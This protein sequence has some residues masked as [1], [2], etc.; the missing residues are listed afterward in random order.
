MLLKIKHFFILYKNYFLM[1]LV[2]TIFFHRIIISEY[3]E[4]MTIGR[5]EFGSLP[6]IDSNVVDE[7]YTLISP[8]I[9]LERFTIP[10]KVYLLDLFGR[11]VH[12]W[13]TK[14]QPFYS[15][16]EK[17]GRL[18]TVMIYPSDIN[19]APGGGLTGIFQEIDWKGNVIWE[20]KNELMHHDFEV[21]PNGN[22]VFQVWEKIPK[23]YSDKIIG[24]Y[25]Q[26]VDHIVWGDALIEVD[27]S[28]KIVWSWHAYEHIP[29][30][31]YKLNSFTPKNEWTHGNSVRFLKEDTGRE[32]FLLSLRHL[33]KVIKIEKKSGGIVWESP[34]GALSYQHDATFTPDGNVLVFDNGLF[35]EQKRPFLWS[36]VVEINPSSNEIVWEFNG[37]KS[38]PERAKFSSS[39]MSGAQRLKNGNT[40]ITE[41]INGHL[42]EVTNTGDVVW[43]FVNP[44]T[45][46]S[47]GGLSNNIV[48]KAR[49]YRPEEIKWP[50]YISSPKPF[51]LSFCKAK[52]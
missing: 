19:S 17:D 11:P 4:S 42:L 9:A 43:D 45:T 20:Y 5:N 46:Y 40:L 26:D 7:S 24:G 37:G 33:N 38:G 14:Y 10:G 28:K 2:I 48:F 44:Y 32:Y 31:K 3:C 35:R 50:S 16:L 27:R 12:T 1:I 49:R 25:W 29:I 13:N 8:F 47:S 51:F 21:L 52:N 18:A 39:I 23:K 34:D 15:Q 22:I 6:V 36:R 30:T 41:S